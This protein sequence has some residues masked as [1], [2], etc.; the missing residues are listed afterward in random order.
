MAL[1]VIF[2]NV[3]LENIIR[4]YENAVCKIILYCVAELPFHLGISRT[5]SVLRGS[6]STF[7]IRY[8]LNRLATYSMLSMFGREQLK[9]VVEKLIESEL[10]QVES[11]SQFD[12]IPVLKI[13][14][15]GQ[16]FIAGEHSVNV[17]FLEGLIDRDIA[18]LDESEKALFDKLKE[19]RLEIA[20]EMALPAY[21][22][23]R[24]IILRELS[25]RKPTDITSLL[26]VS[27]I[28]DKFAENYGMKFLE[29]IIHHVGGKP[30]YPEDIVYE[31]GVVETS[32]P[33]STT[34]DFPEVSR[35][36]SPERQLAEQKLK[37]IFDLDHFYD[38]QWETI[39]RLMNGERI[40]L[41]E[42]TGFG[43]SLCYQFPA[44]QL[45]G[46]TVIFSP[47]IALMRDQ[48]GYLK[49][50]G[51]PAECVNSE[52]EPHENAAILQEARRGT[53]KMLYIAPER[54][55]SRQWQ[56]AVTQFDLSMVVVDEAH[57][58]S[59][60]GH[61]FR[62]AFRKIIDLVRLLPANLPVLA[63]TATA[64]QRVA[65]D[66]MV[67]MGGNVSLLRGNLLRKNLNL[68][69]VRVDSQDAKMEWLGEFLSTQQG[70]GLIYTGR[71]VDTDWYA[72]WLQ[73]LGISAV[74]YNAGLD[75][76]SRK[77]IEEGLQSN[78]WRCVVSTNALG[79]GID[80]PDIR[81]IIHTQMPASP[82]H[83]Y[84]EIGR[85]GR[86]GLPSEIVLLY[87][88][89]DKD[90][91]EYFIKTSRPATRLYLKVIESLKQEP[92]G[93]YDLTRRTNLNQNQ[94]RVI[95]NDLI[96]Q[97]I[98]QG[99]IQGG[100]RKY[101]CLPN[102]PPLDTK[103]FELLRQ[104]K[105]RELRKMIAYAQ[106]QNCRMDYL[107]SYLGDAL[108]ERCGRCDNDLGHRH[109]VSVTDKWE[110]KIQGFQD[111]YF[112]ELNVE[113]LR[114]NLVNGVASS[115]YGFSDVGATIHHCKYENGGYF[116]DHLLVQTLKAYRKHFGYEKFDLVVYVPPTESG[117]LVEN[118][119]R[120]VARNLHFPI[121]N[122]LK[123]MRPTEPQKVFQNS[124]LKRDNV[125][126][127]FIYDNPSE[128]RGKSVLVIDDIIDSGATI[129][130]IGR[131]FTKLGAAKI[132][133]LVIAKTV[134]GDI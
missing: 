33:I 78:R 27:G 60:W 51:I 71:R 133:P 56:N 5:M 32:A 80:K 115:Y 75:K 109:Q 19:L 107:C 112:P 55:E 43:K 41:I 53:I 24:D 18:E 126:E 105:F 67:Q 31:Q 127:A 66:I 113:T 1:M 6:K 85:A 110:K 28:G 94:I 118:F 10:L 61:D 57:C 20:R 22:V 81:F 15:K 36:D 124:V 108:V 2:M 29:V 58:V 130:E 50:L 68:S 90:L 52:Q 100:A 122:G 84:Q 47:L 125:K 9:A 69:V 48:V 25:K 77:E 16:D 95:C 64:T 82:T 26:S 17:Q 46:I 73:S 97:G 101:E 30:E 76:E 11:A 79:M 129:K 99:A 91:P 98:V 40:L 3:D 12:N 37:Q 103:P 88:P 38:M 4:D 106:S 21:M 121:S 34:Q 39:Q 96:D 8:G 116:P 92:L 93:L 123:K 70:T 83:Y 63:T 86:D 14:E 114:S 23:C 72:S 59:M 74:N 134:G 117:D 44:T 131:M 54:Q 111:A 45:P 89:D 7:V 120:R 62:P 102:A 13:T 49:S 104:F 132:A 65:E 35:P 119:A 87:S 42:K 128:I